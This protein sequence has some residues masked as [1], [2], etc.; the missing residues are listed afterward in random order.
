MTAREKFQI[1]DRVQ[2]SEEYRKNACRYP[3]REGEITGFVWYENI[4]KV[5]FDGNKRSTDFHSD[6]LEKVAGL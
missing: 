5:K 1:G 6:F 2:L 4:V 3:N